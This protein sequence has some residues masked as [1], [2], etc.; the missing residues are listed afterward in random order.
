M[1]NFVWLAAPGDAVSTRNR[2]AV[3]LLVSG[4][5][6]LPPDIRDDPRSLL[7]APGTCPLTIYN[8]LRKPL[9]KRAGCDIK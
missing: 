3:D 1:N 4:S 7:G 6:I 5:H 9:S 8:V 2:P